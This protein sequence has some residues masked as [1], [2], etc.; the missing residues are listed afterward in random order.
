MPTTAPGSARPRWRRVAG[1]GVW[2][3]FVVALAAAAGLVLGP[4]QRSEPPPSA[5][6]LRRHFEAS[7]RWMKVHEERVLA[8][9][10][11]MLWRMVRDA[12][13]LSGDATLS[14]MVRRHRERYFTR[15]PVDAWV[16]MLDPAATPSA[17]LPSGL[18]RLPEYMKLMAYGL[19]CDGALGATEVVSRQLRPN[20]CSTFAARRVL[21][22]SK[23]ATH[24]LAGVM[25]MAQRGCGDP[26]RVAALTQALQ[27]RV[28]EELSLDFVVRDEHLQ[29]VLMLYWTGAPERV[30]PVWLNRLLRAQQP[31]GGWFYEADL[32]GWLPG[33]APPASTDFHATAQGLLVIAM[34]LQQGEAALGRAPQNRP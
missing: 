18:A 21:R 22:Q 11:P 29:R 12:A 2:T 30:K 10:N 9:G 23:C 33:R 24:Q 27:D 28:V 17:A 1:R 32:S 4:A 7:L 8:D 25:L 19:T 34:A 6:Q 16:L 20:Y 14:D 26:A 3:L 13:A 5:E 31:D 15:A